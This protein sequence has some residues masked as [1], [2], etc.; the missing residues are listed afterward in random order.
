[1]PKFALLHTNYI[2]VGSVLLASSAFFLSQF[3]FG[4]IATPI[5]SPA[6]PDVSVKAPLVPRRH[7]HDPTY[8][9]TDTN[10]NQSLAGTYTCFNDGTWAH[11]AQINLTIPHIC[12]EPVHDVPEFTPFSLTPNADGAYNHQLSYYRL[13]WL[14]FD[15][16]QDCDATLK[17]G[18]TYA[19]F[20]G[21]DLRT[22]HANKE[23]CQYALGR[24]N[25][26]CHGDNGYT[27]GGW[28][29][30]IDGTSYGFDP[31]T[32]GNNQ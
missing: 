27:R 17:N 20:T 24:T 30:Y 16:S 1:M 13:N 4:A 3:L 19:Y 11:Q 2:V 12:G 14:C 32:N 9:G 23:A 25:D 29:T 26:L 28:F 15:I 31:Q 10:A 8:G 6:A 18:D 21:N 7:K 22:D 5:E